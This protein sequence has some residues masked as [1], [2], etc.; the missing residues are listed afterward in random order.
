M[1]EEIELKTENINLKI[2]REDLGLSQKEFGDKLNISDTTIS[3][4]EKGQRSITDRTFSQICNTFNVRPEW[5]KTGQGEKYT[6]IDDI[7]ISSMMGKVFAN[8]DDFLKRVF[9]TFSKLNDSE[10][11]VVMKIINELSDKE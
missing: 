1:N 5:L 6:T 10:R 7:S 2:L 3:K 11:A 9:L 4:Y 8:D